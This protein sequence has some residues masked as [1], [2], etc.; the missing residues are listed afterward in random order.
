MLEVLD[1][2]E[3]S[4]KKFYYICFLQHALPLMNIGG[5]KGVFKFM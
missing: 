5:I 3:K 1:N 4:G 2:Y